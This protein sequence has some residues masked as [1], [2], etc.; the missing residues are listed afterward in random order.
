MNKLKHKLLYYRIVR[1]IKRWNNYDKGY[2]RYILDLN[3]GY[4]FYYNLT[5]KIVR[6]KP[7]N[8]IE[9]ERKVIFKDCDT[10]Y[11]LTPYLRELLTEIQND[12]L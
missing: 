12:G 9:T 6:E 10:P 4:L 8:G 7:L 5:G 2:N 1:M 11:Q 3:D